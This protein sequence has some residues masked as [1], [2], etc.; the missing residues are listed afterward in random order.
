MTTVILFV[1]GAIIGSFLN[2]VGLRFRSG[3][4]LG[5]RSRCSTCR[6]TL[7]WYEL[8]PIA[9]FLFLRGRC[10]HCGTRF[11]FL[12]PLIELWSALVFAT[13][14]LVAISIL[15]SLSLLVIFSLFLVIVIYDLRHTIIPNELVYPAITLSILARLLVFTSLFDWLTGP[16]LFVLFAAIWFFSRGRAMGFGDAKLALAIGL[17]LGGAVGFSAVILSFWAGALYGLVAIGLSRY[18]PLLMKGKTIT[19]KSEVPFAPFLILGAWLALIF[20]LDLLHV[21]LF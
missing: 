16:I 5:G 1:C 10:R 7:E 4:S 21:A 14:P 13:I 15:Q 6:T 3:L 18:S 19:M 11:S 2:V 12:Y 9:S 17:L 20:Q 8:I